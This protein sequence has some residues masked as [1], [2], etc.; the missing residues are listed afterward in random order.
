MDPRAAIQQPGDVWVSV[1]KPLTGLGAIKVRVNPQYLFFEKGGLRTDSQQVPLAYVTDVDANQSM[2]QK[3]RQVGTLR[4][5][6]QRGGGVETVLLEDLPDFREGVRIINELAH[7]ARMYEQR[8]QNTQTVNYQGQPFQQG[9]PPQQMPQH[10][11]PPQQ[12]PVPQQSPADAVFAQLEKLGEMKDK[13]WI[14]DEEF[15][16]KKTELLGRL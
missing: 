16:A 8:A 6:V 5:H 10:Q 3:V 12:P 7:N 4:V 14:S 9:P 11:A 13:G 2:Q 1:G 15:Q